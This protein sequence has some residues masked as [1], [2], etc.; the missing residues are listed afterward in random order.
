M[1]KIKKIIL[2]SILCGVLLSPLFF[3]QAQENPAP[4]LG[5]STPKISPPIDFPKL[6]VKLPGLNFDKAICTSTECSN[7]W[8]AEYIQA[9]YQYGISVIAIL[10]VITLMI[11]GVIWLTAAGN[12]QRIGEAKKWIGG[13]LMGVLIALTS[14]VVLNMVNPALT[15]LS[16]IKVAYIQYAELPEL[17]AEEQILENQIIESKPLGSLATGPEGQFDK[18]KSTEYI[19]VHTAAYNATRDQVNRQHINEGIKGTKGIKA[20]GYNLYIE[21]DGTLVVGRGKD[22]RGAHTKNYNNKGLGIAYSGCEKIN[23]TWISNQKLTGAIK[24]DT[25]KQVQLNTLVNTI[26]SLQA[27][28]RVPR[29]KVLGHTETNGGVACPCLDMNELRSLINP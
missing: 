28:Y 8:L 22:A 27:E 9:L 4:D 25:I 10:A 29:E 18:R 14:Y 13:S 20:I 19:I 11:A 17:S 12:Q 1:N 7:N 24:N 3:V 5:A 21:R 15:E 26:K 2:L 6:S 16:P 23:G